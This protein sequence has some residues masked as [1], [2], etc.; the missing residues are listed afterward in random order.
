VLEDWSPTLEGLFLYYPGHRQVPATL[1]P[2][3]HDPLH[4]RQA[5]QEPAEESIYEAL[6][7]REV[8]GKFASYAGL[9]RLR[10]RSPYGE[11]KA[12]VSITFQKSLSKKMDCRVKPGNDGRFGVPTRYSAS[13]C[14]VIA[15]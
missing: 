14:I 5:G 9:T 8:R 6:S 4:P 15:S 1:R 3:R 2:H 12:R 7:A 11:A 10:G 13:R